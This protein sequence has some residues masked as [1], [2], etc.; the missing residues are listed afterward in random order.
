MARRLCISVK[1]L[2]QRYHGEEWP[3]SPARLFQA[4][5]AGANTGCRVLDGSSSHEALKWFEELSPPEIIASDATAGSSYRAYTPN[6]DTDS[7]EVVALVGK[8]WSVPDAIR[9]KGLLAP[10]SKQ[11]A[12]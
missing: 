8:G 11:L 2:A 7:S 12:C 1:F 9:R 3:P 6:N 5:V 4:F 10:K